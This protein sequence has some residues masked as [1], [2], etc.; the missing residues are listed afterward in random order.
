M[1][2]VKSVNVNMKVIK[3]SKRNHGNNLVLRKSYT[4]KLRRHYYITKRNEEED[5]IK[6]RD[7]KREKVEMIK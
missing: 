5:L 1:R 7:I 6:W 3:G 2:G 4:I